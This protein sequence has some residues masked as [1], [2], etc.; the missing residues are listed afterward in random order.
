MIINFLDD[1]R[2][3]L[4]RNLLVLILIPFF[5]FTMLSLTFHVEVNQIVLN[6]PYKFRLYEL[7]TIN[8]VFQ[9][10]T[11]PLH[12]KYLVRNTVIYTYG[13][14]SIWLFLFGFSTYRVLSRNNNPN[15][16]LILSELIILVLVNY[17]IISPGLPLIFELIIWGYIIL[18]I[19]ILLLYWMYY[20]IQP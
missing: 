7:Q 16:V 11:T 15:Y 12:I 2:V 13:L 20:R 14:Y 18:I 6:E 3:S 8:Y 19:V 4:K 10:S 17:F 1:L 5:I 9:H